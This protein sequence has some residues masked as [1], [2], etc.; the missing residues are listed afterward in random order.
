MNVQI[1]IL[2]NCFNKYDEPKSFTYYQNNA[3]KYYKYYTL[4]NQKITI[5]IMII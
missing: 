3:K 5:L 2:K 4:N 1:Q